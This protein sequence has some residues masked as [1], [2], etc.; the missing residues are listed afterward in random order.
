VLYDPRILVLDE[1]TSNID[2]EAERAIQDALAVLVRGRTTIAIAHRLSTL[3]NADRILAF[4]RGRLAEQGTH[5]ELLAAD[6][7]YARLVRLQTQVSKHPSVD[8]L[9][10]AGG[11]AEAV[12]VPAAEPAVAGIEWLDPGSRHFASGP[13]GRIDMHVGDD[14]EAGIFVVPAFPASHPECWLSVRRWSEAG[15]DVEIGMIRALAEWDA[16]DRAVLRTALRRRSL[17][18]TIRGIH[19]VRLLQG[20]L[21]F[22]VDTD[23]G[24]RSFSTRWTQGQVLDFGN[25]GRMLIDS[26]ENRWVIPRVDDLPKADQER[27]LHYVYW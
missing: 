18:R 27:F 26:D 4:D 14:V 23:I 5:A 3:R 11:D 15:D 6:G 21:D 7:I 10:D 8:R 1:A 22:D 16:A 17:V 12:P 2:A 13:L 25:G 19:R 9:L 20:F 24:R